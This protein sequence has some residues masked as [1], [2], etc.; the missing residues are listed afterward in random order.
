MI[1]G[2]GMTSGI[3]VV[4]DEVTFW[5]VGTGV[6]PITIVDVAVDWVE[7]AVEAQPHTKI[8]RTNPIGRIQILRISIA[9]CVTTINLSIKT[10]I[11]RFC[12]QIA[13]VM[14]GLYTLNMKK[15]P[16]LITG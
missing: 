8:T 10:H 5:G 2:D 1:V 4:S 16:V 12:W 13:M 11:L 6:V 9:Y 3:T 7:G 15:R 14:E